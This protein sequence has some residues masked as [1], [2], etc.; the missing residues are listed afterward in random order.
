MASHER[1]R[2]DEDYPLFLHEA[3]GGSG[4]CLGARAGRTFRADLHCIFMK[5]RFEPWWTEK[6]FDKLIMAE[7]LREKALELQRQAQGLI[8][9]ARILETTYED[10]AYST[11]LPAQA[12]FLPPLQAE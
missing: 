1:R 6:G 11:Q 12:S 7:C 10:P 5:I 8:E 9:A 3:V 4:A 2:G